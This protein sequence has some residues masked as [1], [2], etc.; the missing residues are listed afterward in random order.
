MLIDTH[1]HLYF[2]QFD[3]DRDET[4]QRAFAA[5]VKKI[6]NIGIDPETCRQSI[7]MAERYDGLFAVVGI[8]PNDA[9]LWSEATCAQLI[10]WRRHPKVV[11]IGEIG[12]DFYWDKTPA[13]VQEN[14]FRQQIRLAKELALPIVIHNREAGREILDVLKSEGVSG[15]SGVFHCFSETTRIAEEIL[16][17][18]FYISFT[19]NLTF[20]KSELSEVAKI[21]PAERLLLETDCP[22]LSPEPKRGRR[23]EPAHVVYIAQK[24]A[25]IKELP[26]EELA[27]ATTANAQRLFGLGS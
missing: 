22:F 2:H 14:V 11:A 7:A 26:F 19:G 25:E 10:E 17:L 18:G 3:D 13:P 12:L 21:I 23:N 4:I 15:L 1:A 27:R 24:L 8:H 6:I 5:G 16:E 9:G 20:K